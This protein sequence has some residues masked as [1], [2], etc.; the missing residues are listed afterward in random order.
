MVWPV[1]S[2]GMMH[3]GLRAGRYVI[4]S[5]VYV[6][7][8]V[9]VF[10]AGM[11]TFID[12]SGFGAVAANV[13]K[14]GWGLISGVETQDTGGYLYNYEFDIGLN[15]LVIGDGI[16]QTV[17]NCRFCNQNFAIT[18]DASVGTTGSQ[19]E[20]NNCTFHNWPNYAVNV[21]AAGCVVDFIGCIFNGAKTNPTY[22]QSVTAGDIMQSQGLLR[23]QGCQFR[24]LPGF[25]VDPQRIGL[26]RPHSNVRLAPLRA[27]SVS[28]FDGI[29]RLHVCE[30]GS[31][32]GG[33]SRQAAY[34]D[35]HGRE[36]R[37]HVGTQDLSGSFRHR[38]IGHSFG[39]LR[40]G[41]R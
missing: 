17:T 5:T 16:N 24:N 7:S 3:V 35:M 39:A 20:F 13:F 2:A 30:C 19:I 38:V 23:L 40:D 36:E 1:Q 32:I 14:L 34:C 18:F 33:K 29:C 37:I 12:S 31:L 4:S 26:V 11:S 6:R 8:G 27:D 15:G 28:G 25:G 9:S 22:A 10:G 41:N 21:A